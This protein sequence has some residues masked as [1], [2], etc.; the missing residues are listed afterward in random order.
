MPHFADSLLIVYCVAILLAGCA[1]A[2]ECVVPSLTAREFSALSL[3][4]IVIGSGAGGMTVASR[5][6]EDHGIHVGLIEAGAFHPNDP[7]ID[8]PAFGGRAFGNS[9]YDWLFET[10]PQDNAG[11]RIIQETRGKMLGGSTGINLLAWDRASKLE[12]DAW[13][14]LMD[15][16]DWN[17]DNLL[18]YFI[19]SETIN[20]TNSHAFPGVSSN[21]YAAADKQFEFDDGFRGPIHAS[22]NS[23]YGDLAIPLA[24][25]WNNLKVP[26]N[27]N[28]VSGKSSGVRNERTAVADGVRS[29]SATAYYCPASA[30]KNLHVLTGA[31]ATQVLFGKR[32]HARDKLT[33][34][35][36]SFINSGVT[37]K[38]HASKEVILA[39]GA[40][41][42]P[43]LLE[44]SGIGNKTILSGLGIETLVDLPGVGS[45]L[46]DHIYTTSQW[47]ALPNI[48]TFDILRYNATFLEEQTALY[49]KTRTGFLNTRSSNLVFLSSNDTM[50]PQADVQGLIAELRGHLSG[51]H[52]SPLERL[53]FEIQLRWLRDGSVPQ[54]EFI[55]QSSGLISPAN[56]TNYMCVVS[57]LMHP[58]SRGT[59]HI[60][61]TDPLAHPVID[62]N[63]LSFDYGMRIHL[64][65]LLVD[66]FAEDLH[67]LRSFTS[68]VME[69]TKHKP[70]ADLLERQDVPSVT[71][72]DS[73]SLDDFVT[74]TFITG[75]HLA[76]TAAM[77]SRRLGGVVD[78]NLRV[79]GVSNLRVVDASI[80]PMIVGAHLQAT[81][82][83]IAEKIRLLILSV[84]DVEGDVLT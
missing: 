22:Y 65:G 74:S 72:V 28:S 66:L 64:R 2:L 39:A 31:Q 81:V 14:L 33:A 77:A 42:T 84:R 60:N 36:V 30:R 63:Y 18:P 83:A 9:T 16:S 76:G 57:G 45:N 1:A 48:T 24:S 56:N 55:T 70:I 5:L 3:D 20:L 35:G 41:Q 32:T 37:Y 47:V 26:T 52:L 23:I 61:S 59:I 51:S 8:I 43:Q 49:E 25:T 80:M 69:V 4:Y 78:A 34:T 44:L 6:T 58:L 15:G 10:V 73:A 54:A 79:Y 17:F 50:F 13:Q 68:I 40:V 19:K 38:A 53:Q 71:T 82:Y 29:Y 7:L 12:Y 62:P 21:A 75:D 11:G 27:P 67:S 46:Q